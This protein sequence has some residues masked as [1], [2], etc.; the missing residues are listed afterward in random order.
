MA[1]MP[2]LD[3]LELAALSGWSKGAVYGAAQELVAEGLAASVSHATDL[4]PPTRRFYLTSAGLELLARE[5]GVSLDELLR[6]RPVSAQWRRSLM[7]RLDGVGVIYR[8]AAAVSNI[9]YPIG[10]RWYRA[11]PQDAAILLPGGGTLLVLRQGA[12]S[13]RTAF[14]KRLF[15]LGEGPRPSAVLMLIPDE[16][17]LRHARRLM[18][19]SPLS[20]LLALESEAASCGPSDAIWRLP[21]AAAVLDLRYALS[22]LGRGSPPPSEPIPA[23]VSMPDDMAVDGEG[24]NLPDHLLPAVLKPA[25][26]RTLDILSDWPWL[27]LSDLRGLTGVSGPRASQLLIRLEGLGLATRSAAQRGRLTLTDRG[28]AL[29]CRRDRTSA[30]TA[31]RRWSASLLKQRAPSDWRNVSGRRSG[32]L[33][34]N[35]EHTGAVHGFI[36]AL[37]SQCRAQGWEVI[38]ID[39]PRRAARYFHRGDRLRSI[40]PDAFGMVSNTQATWPFFLEWERRAVR[41]AT[42]AVRLAPYM[43]YFSSQR[44]TDDH[45]AQPAVLVVFAGDIAATHFLRVASEEMNRTRVHLPLWVSHEAALEELGPLERAWRAPGSWEPTYAFT[46][47]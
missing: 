22:G 36:T 2:F 29:L 39:P 31:K 1:S 47:R 26:K 21:S 8:L 17:R 11:A 10:L 28:L 42:M 4:I 37:T 33:L 44:P 20:A 3:R 16:V 19:R 12:T 6:T 15:R 40:H 18:A 27:V 24:H 46:G 9:A 45:G 43:R 34:R 32:Q 5:D 30:P 14:A 23:R 7:E 25:E 38:Q 13:D 41:P 35:I